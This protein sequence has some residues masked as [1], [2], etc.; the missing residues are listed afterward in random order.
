MATAHQRLEEH[1]PN[2]ADIERPSMQDLNEVEI[3]T[4]EAE[5]DLPQKA[6]VR[7][8][9]SCR[10]ALWSFLLVVV[11][12]GVALVMM[13]RMKPTTDTNG[14]SLQPDAPRVST[15]GG[16]LR[17][18]LRVEHGNYKNVNGSPLA[19][20]SEPGEATTGFMRD[21]HCTEVQDDS[22]SHHICIKMEQDFCDVTGQGNWC[23][24]LK[25]PSTGNGIGHWCVCQWAF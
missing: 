17:S 6:A 10:I 16:G 18:S 14:E 1:T 25:D 22:G 2:E 12:A 21:G 7:Y 13:T 9:S 24:T 3:G 11:V 4:D 8:N 20:C 5:E 23:S 19:S 15:I